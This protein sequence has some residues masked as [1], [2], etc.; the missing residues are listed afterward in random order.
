MGVLLE[1]ELTGQ[2]ARYGVA[3]AD[4]EGVVQQLVNVPSIHLMGLMT[5]APFS[6]DPED[7]RPTFTRLRHVRDHMQHVTGLGAAGVE[8][9][10]EQRLRD[11]RGGGSH[12]GPRGPGNLRRAGGV[13]GRRGSAASDLPVSLR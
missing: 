10:H 11:R 1:V 12:D 6:E 9:G 13:G 2:P 8:H 3:E 4:V 7:A 5:I